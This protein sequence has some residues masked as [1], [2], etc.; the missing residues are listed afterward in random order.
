MST[1]PRVDIDLSAFWQDPYPMLARLRA[2]APIAFVPQLGGTVF[3]RRDDIFI[4]EKQIDIFSSHQPEGLMN[5]L[6]GHNM[7]RKDGEAHLSERKAIFPSVSPKTV[8][9]VWTAQ[10]Q[11]HADRILDELLPQGR[12]EFCKGF[13]LPFSA[14]CLKS[15]TGLTNM[16]FEDMD[17]WSQGMIDGI[18]NY[19]G[20]PK[21]EA[22][23]HAATAGIDAAIDDMA[24]V[25]AKA[26]NQSLLSVML[27]A[28][29][30][31]QSVRANVKL[32]ISGGQNEP[33]D[34]VAGTV[35]ALLTH[36]EQ[37]D[38]ALAGK[39]TWLQVF[40]EYARWISPIGMSPRRIARAWSIRDIAFEPDDRIFFMFGSANR[41]ERHFENPEIFDVRRDASKSIAFGAGPHFC[42]GAWASRA[43]LAEVALPTIFKRLAGLR[44]AP[45]EPVR[46]GGWAFRGLL[47]LPV[48]WDVP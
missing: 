14:E 32:A 25:L 33:R 26:P 16:R 5:R 39:V 22:R 45:H 38:M 2:Q 30:P 20:D 48:A 42:A 24:P 34:A 36:P 1:A 31:M 9:L 13:A 40:E 43:M 10:F 3:T 15:I 44:V 41:D 19:V 21:V 37:L 28:G 29:M 35:W 7:M 12:T 27:A 17:A 46:I 6:M 8:K 4:S 18:A 47:N 11:A 23:C